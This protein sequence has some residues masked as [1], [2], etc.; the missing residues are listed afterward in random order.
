MNNSMDD[1]AFR[2]A[3]GSGYSAAMMNVADLIRLYRNKGHSGC[4]D[5]LDDLADAVDDLTKSVASLPA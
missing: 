4:A 3:Y 5:L 2:R 1:T